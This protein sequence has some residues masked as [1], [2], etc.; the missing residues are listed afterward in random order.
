L[1]TSFWF[2]S[3]GKQMELICPWWTETWDFGCKFTIDAT[4]FPNLVSLLHY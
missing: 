4:L 3:E 2:Q 1:M